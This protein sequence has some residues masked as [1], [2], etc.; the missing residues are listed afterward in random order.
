MTLAKPMFPP[1]AD[2]LRAS[3][4]AGLARQERRRQTAL[5]R[6]AKL[7][8]KASAEIVRLIAFLDASDT[9]VMSELEDQVDDGPIDD[10]EL[11]PSVGPD[12]LELDASDLEP[13]L[14]SLD[15]NHGQE[16]W[17]AGSRQDLE[18][19]GAESGIGDLD[20]LL[21]QVGTQDWQQGAMA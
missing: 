18:L 11:E 14:G 6:L 19:D 1:A 9:Y 5:R 15:H 4:P 21:E 2:R 3:K 10:T 17:A 16:R 12:D 13:S 20:G 7:R 8:A